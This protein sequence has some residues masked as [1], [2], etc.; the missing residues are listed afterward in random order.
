MST[1]SNA[2]A[3]A[4]APSE[5]G[6]EALRSALQERFGHPDFR[7]GQ[8]GVIQSVLT[9][10]P[11]LAVMPTGSGKSLC[12]QLPSLLLPGV[13][14][15]VSP[16]VA[17]MKDQVDQLRQRGIPAAFINSS[18]SEADRLVTEKEVAAGRL[19]LV[20]VAPERFRSAAFRRALT[21]V[22]VSLLAIDEAH[23]ISEWGH[24]F[25]PDYERLGEAAAELRAPRLLALTATATRDVRADIVRALRLR[26][27]AVVVTGFD[28]PNIHLEV[29]EL[30][31]EAE[32]R[33]TMV[34]AVR[35]FRPAIVYT[36]TRLQATSLARLLIMN[37]IRAEPY[38]AGLETKVRE[39]TQERFC[40]DDIDAVTA[41][42]AFGLGIDKPDVRL[43]LHCEMPRSV[44]SY[45]QEIGRAGRDGRA[46]YA[47]LLYRPGDLFLMR[48]ILNFGAPAPEVVAALF[49]TLDASREPLPQQRLAQNLPKGANG[50]QLNAALAFLESVGLVQR[51]FATG[52]HE[53]IARGTNVYAVVPGRKLSDENLNRLRVRS[54][55]DRQ[56]QEHMLALARQETCRRAALLRE[57]GE[58]TAAASCQACD[59]CVGARLKAI[60]SRLPGALVRARAA[61][62]MSVP[63]G[64]FPVPR[65]STASSPEAGPV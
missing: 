25:R 38:H 7:R 8:L 44:E 42:N 23:C 2:R 43:V 3:V 62:D 50:N 54:F 14:L 4:G 58:P 21:Q 53:E 31:R 61:W 49:K 26:N 1:P 36:A 45:Y 11:T 20:Y 63:A 6:A 39:R 65:K 52:A 57:L 64:T 15:V 19:K 46:A 9:G 47:G 12:Y 28:R 40:R 5:W 16:L 37:D 55:R 34:A 22:Q 17:L 59:V 13:T 24:S 32:Q 51:Q 48:R 29:H 60:R 41:T 30:A 35:A 10:R 18:Q 33:D 27:P 56:R